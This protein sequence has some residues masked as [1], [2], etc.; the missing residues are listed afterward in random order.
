MTIDTTPT[1]E[2][3]EA[4]EAM[5]RQPKVE[6]KTYGEAWLWLPEGEY[7]ESQLKELVASFERMRAHRKAAVGF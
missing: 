6:H 7:T 4:F 2:E 3:N 1:P 5:S